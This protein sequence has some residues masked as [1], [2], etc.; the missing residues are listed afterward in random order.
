MP[1]SIPQVDA[2]GLADVMAAGHSVVD[3][4]QPNE[5][6]NGHVPGAV[7]VPLQELPDRMAELPADR[8]LHLICRSG[9]RSLAAAEF[10]AGQGVEAVNVAGGM[11]AWVES[12]RPVVTGSSP[13]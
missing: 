7:L 2:A 10:L 9:A 3:V 1:S 11:L 6:V 12:G 13:S 4:R 5:Y 8:P